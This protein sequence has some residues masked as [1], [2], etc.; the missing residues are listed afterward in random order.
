MKVNYDIGNSAGLGFNMVEELDQYGHH[1][2]DIHIKDRLLNGKSVL[3]GQGNANFELFFDTLLQYKYE[4]IFIMQAYRDE[5]GVEI[6]K[7][8]LNF[9]KP[10]LKEFNVS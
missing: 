8:Q 7:K 1:I 9:I 5:E 2:S 4:G 10:F 3:L 6:F